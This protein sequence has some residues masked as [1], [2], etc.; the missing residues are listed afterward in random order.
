M[1][2]FL[3]FLVSRRI[4]IPWSWLVRRILLAKGVKVGKDFYIEGIPYLKIRGKSSNIQIGENVKIFGHV[5]FRNRE[6]GK[7]IIGNDVEIDNDCRFV[8]A[9]NATLELKDKCFIGPYSVFNAG[10]DIIIGSYTISGGFVHIQSSN[11]GIS[12][13]EKIWLQKHT[14][15][16]ILIG[17]DVWLGAN[18][19]ILKGVTIGNGSILAAKC[20]VTKDVSAWK[21]VAGI[22]AKEISERT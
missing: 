4:Y 19:T 6:N 17:E 12:K 18:C 9:N 11:H 21:I 13:N 5:D 8:A 20:V 16:K 2:R 22:P 14:Y 7:I 10:D 1:L 15:G 3:A